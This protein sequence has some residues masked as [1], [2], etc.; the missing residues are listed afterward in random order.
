MI[1]FMFIITPIS[2]EG[3][4]FE[5]FDWRKGKML[6]SKKS[7]TILILEIGFPQRN[8]PSTISVANCLIES[9]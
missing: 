1:L 4:I 8:F 3:I 6:F 2:C 7:S 5:T 9:W